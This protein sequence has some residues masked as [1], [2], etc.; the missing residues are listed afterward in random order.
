MHP[1]QLE[2]PRELRLEV[3]ELT[4]AL[5]DG[6]RAAFAR[7]GLVLVEVVQSLRL[8]FVGD[9]GVATGEEAA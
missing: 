7:H 3:V 6:L 2:L 1:D 5:G 9:A 4:D 8:D